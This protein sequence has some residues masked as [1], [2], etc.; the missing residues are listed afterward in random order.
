MKKFLPSG[1]FEAKLQVRPSDPDLIAFVKKEIKKY[2]VEVVDENKL[3]E[4]L[5]IYINSANFAIRMGKIF[6]EK[7]KIKPKVSK[8]L[9]GENKQA[10][11]L[12]YKLT[13]L[14]KI[15]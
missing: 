15:N 5:D 9:K 10:G 12:I 7:Y 1:Y 14:L 8:S 4:G 13:V 11:K 2:D 6:R 3:K